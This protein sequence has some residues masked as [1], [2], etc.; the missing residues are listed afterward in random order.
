MIEQTLLYITQ[1][2]LMVTIPATIALALV[3]SLIG[4]WI[5]NEI[6]TY[7]EL[8]ANNEIVGIKFSYFG[9]IFAVSL[10][11]ALIGAYSLYIGV[12]EVSTSEVTALRSLYYSASN[13]LD[14]GADSTEALKR[15][16]VV[17]YARSVAEEEWA[18]QANSGM[19]E[20]TTLALRKMFDAFTQNSDGNNIVTT[21][22]SWLNDVVKS[23]VMRTT[24]LTR[25]LSMLVWI[26]LI[27]GTAMSIIVPLFVGTPN[28][29]I[30]SILSSIFS[31]FIM[32]HLLVI[33][34]LAYPFSGDVAIS[35]EI[36]RD[37]VNETQNAGTSPEPQ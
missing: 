8:A 13:K 29:I 4:T 5:S 25:S 1:A 36:Y 17:A 3:L 2:P 28:F 11:L 37:F 14:L 24:T 15:D 34:H 26:I 18:M 23:R 9:E 16:A 27:I 12:R 10:G 30:Q 21:Q 19:S 31:A 33:V 35:A 32:L 20:K 7:S 22:M 6:Y